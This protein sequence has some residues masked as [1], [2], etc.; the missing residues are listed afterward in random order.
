MDGRKIKPIGENSKKY[1]NEYLQDQFGTSDFIRYSRNG[2]MK[3]VGSAYKS[4]NKKANSHQKTLLKGL[5]Q[6]IHSTKNAYVEIDNKSRFGFSHPA[7]IE[8]V[9]DKYGFPVPSHDITGYHLVESGITHK[10]SNGCY[11]YINNEGAAKELMTAGL[12]FE[13]H[14]RDKDYRPYIPSI[15]YTGESASSVFFHELLDEFLNFF[16]RHRTSDKSPQ[17]DKVYYQNQALLNKGLMPR[18]G[19]DHQ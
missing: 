16:T 10:E 5:K 12:H 13:N 11:I 14:V 4:L 9:H 6:A 8:D 17:I 1:I 15:L 19:A 7:Y 3:I 18:D 2:N